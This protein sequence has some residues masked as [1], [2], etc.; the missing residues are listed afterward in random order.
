MC[1]K[2]IVFGI[3]LLVS[4]ALLIFILSVIANK[5][6]FSEN[7]KFEYIYYF[8]KIMT[9]NSIVS[10]NHN[11]EIIYDFSSSGEAFGLTSNY[12]NFLKLTNKEGCIE[13]YKP[14]GI[15]DTIGHKLCIDETLDCPINSMKVDSIQRTDNYLDE[16]YLYAPLSN[17]TINYRFFYSN[18]YPERNVRI[19]I[20]ETK[21]E[22][23]YLSQ[24]IL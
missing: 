8:S 10:N 24:T 5:N 6:C 16:N 18:I 9:I 17:I 19:I 1:K 15:L 20:I 3:L 2:I 13:N 4:I 7:K 23:K 22:P 14:C 21:D 12:K 11:S